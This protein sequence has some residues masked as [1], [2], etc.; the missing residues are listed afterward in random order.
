ME[1][2]I[3][4]TEEDSQEFEGRCDAEL[5]AL[6]QDER[7]LERAQGDLQEAIRPLTSRKSGSPLNVPAHLDESE[8]EPAFRLSQNTP[9][10]REKSVSR[11]ATPV[12]VKRMQEKLEEATTKHAE[13]L[14]QRDEKLAKLEEEARAREA[15]LDEK[16]AK[17]EQEARAREA[18]LAEFAQ[19]EKER[20][21]KYLMLDETLARSQE[22]PAR[23]AEHH[24]LKAENRQLDTAGNDD[25]ALDEPK[26]EKIR[27]LLVNEIRAQQLSEVDVFDRIAGFSAEMSLFDFRSAVAQLNYQSSLIS[28]QNI[29]RAQ[30]DDLFGL[31]S[32]GNPVTSDLRCESGI[33]DLSTNQFVKSAPSYSK[34]AAGI[35]RQKWCCWLQ[36]SKPA[37]FSSEHSTLLKDA[38]IGISAEK[39]DPGWG[40]WCEY[41]ENSFGSGED[42]S[43]NVTFRSTKPCRSRGYYELTVTKKSLSQSSF[44]FVSGDFQGTDD[45]AVGE[46]EHGWG[47]DAGE[48]TRRHM[49]MFGDY[50]CEWK[51]NDVVGFACDLESQKIFVSLNGSCR[52]PNGLVFRLSAGSLKNGIYAAF[53]CRREDGDQALS[54]LELGMPGF[55]YKPP[56]LHEDGFDRFHAIYCKTDDARRSRTIRAILVGI[57]VNGNFKSCSG[58]NKSPWVVTEDQLKINAL[59][60]KIR[61]WQLDISQ[62]DL[63][64]L[65]SQM[66]LDANTSIRRDTWDTAIEKEK[67]ACTDLVRILSIVASALVWDVRT[68]RSAFPFRSGNTKSPIPELIEKR[69]LIDL[70]DDL[71]LCLSD[72]EV[73]TWFDYMDSSHS[74]RVSMHSWELA[75]EPFYRAISV[76]GLA[77]LKS[78]DAAQQQFEQLDVDD[79]GRLTLSEL[80]KVVEDPTLAP[81]IKCFQGPLKDQES[82]LVHIE[83]FYYHMTHFAG[84]SLLLAI[85]LMPYSI[86]CLPCKLCSFSVWDGLL[87]RAW[88]AHITTMHRPRSVRVLSAVV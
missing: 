56:W 30:V 14:K 64:D 6:Q 63:G 22:A 70:N 11:A 52:P 43:K 12:E 80:K 49:G 58:P 27:Q 50:P 85:A 67:D 1:R 77:L 7:E 82:L 71:Q 26:N 25:V 79:N 2:E 47:I 83:I 88:L 62:T 8:S 15:R 53:T 68:V 59:K 32:R 75:I 44:G 16:L 35:S 45:R 46:D 31:L 17:L 13:E 55:K 84:A 18:R 65:L 33:S 51:E 37:N 41:P 24:E 74:G 72:R 81:S 3:D 36:H 61:E 5:R 66:K 42:G 54:T 4:A 78:K 38:S 69:D 28:E 48:R 29:S 86:A 10:T 20:E 9:S 76:M 73:T 39:S 87:G 21:A 40:D 60:V 34:P 23:A 57:K 19:R